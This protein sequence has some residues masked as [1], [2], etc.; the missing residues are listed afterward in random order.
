M[1]KYTKKYLKEL[2]E[3]SILI[4]LTY[5]FTFKR[6]FATQRDGD[7]LLLKMFII[8]ILKL[9]LDP[10]TTEISVKCSELPKE[11]SHEYRKTVD[12]NVILNKDIHLDIEMNNTKYN[13][14]VTRNGLYE[15]KLFTM[16]FEAGSTMEDFLKKYIYQLNLNNYEKINRDKFI[17]EIEGEDIIAFTS[18]KNGNVYTNK[19]ITILKYLDYYK[20][21]Y[22]NNPN[23]CKTDDIWLVLLTSSS[24]TELGE[25]VYKIL[26]DELANIF[27]KE[28]ISMSKDDFILHD[29][30]WEK[31]AKL[32]EAEEKLYYE[33]MIEEG[34][35]N[36]IEKG[37]KQGIEQGIEKGIEKGIETGIEREKITSIKNMLKNNLDYKLISNITG[38]TIKEIKEIEQS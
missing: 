27:I 36:G 18:M 2:D 29:W 21:L 12:I 8:S 30:E 33:N 11:N 23:K 16:A 32:K 3:N 20:N 38:K 34:I 15:A 31:M 22:Y 17:E 26:P 35:K 7:Y 9:D 5:D 13:K 37:I 19:R 6:L 14:I 10:M 4:P 24:F 25:Y 28:A 1:I